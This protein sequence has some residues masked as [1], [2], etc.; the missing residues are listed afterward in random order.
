MVIGWRPVEGE[1]IKVCLTRA[2]DSNPPASCQFVQYYCTVVILVVSYIQIVS[3]ADPD[4]FFFFPGS[5]YV[6]EIRVCYGSGSVDQSYG[7]R[8]NPEKLHEK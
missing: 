2:T 5:G 6:P 1:Q 7:S 3:H 8:S 4:Y